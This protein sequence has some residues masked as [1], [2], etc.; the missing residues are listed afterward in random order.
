M[1]NKADDNPRNLFGFYSPPPAKEAGDLTALNDATPPTEVTTYSEVIYPLKECIA[2]AG[3]ALSFNP[4]GQDNSDAVKILT[5]LTAAVEG[6]VS[7]QPLLTKT[8]TMFGA[9]TATEKQ[10]TEEPKRKVFGF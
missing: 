2:S 8:G 9:T 4:G 1:A 7:T 10:P 5:D 6:I 3:K